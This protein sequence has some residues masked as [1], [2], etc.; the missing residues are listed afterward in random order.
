MGPPEISNKG[1]VL[2]MG[3]GYSKFYFKS[4]SYGGIFYDEFERR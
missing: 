2:I 1:N 3:R 4:K